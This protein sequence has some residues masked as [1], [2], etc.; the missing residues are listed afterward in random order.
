MGDAPR[1]DRAS[2]RWGS[3][4]DSAS[5]SSSLVPAFLTVASVNRYMGDCAARAAG[6]RNSRPARAKM[7]WKWAELS[8]ISGMVERAAGDVSAN[9]RSLRDTLNR[10]KCIPKP[11]SLCVTD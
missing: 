4:A 1:P 10:S 8:E 9:L 11:H 7:V 6:V 3:G 2:L 5:T